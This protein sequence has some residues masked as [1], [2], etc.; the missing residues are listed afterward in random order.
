MVGVAKSAPVVTEGD[1][2]EFEFDYGENGPAIQATP[3][4]YGTPGEYFVTA[5]VENLKGVSELCLKKILR[6]F[7]TVI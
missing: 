6:A 4:T 5:T 3:Y 1:Y 2:L 7:H